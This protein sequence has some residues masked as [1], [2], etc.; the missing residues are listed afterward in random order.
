MPQ[1]VEHWRSIAPR[2]PD[3]S[4]PFLPLLLFVARAAAP[5]FVITRISPQAFPAMANSRSA[6]KRDHDAHWRWG[7]C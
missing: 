5:T 2:R 3:S 6:D 4:K 7:G 1:H